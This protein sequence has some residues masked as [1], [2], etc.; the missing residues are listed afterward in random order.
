MLEEIASE[1]AI[2]R[3]YRSRDFPDLDEIKRVIGESE[4]VYAVG[5]GTSY[6][7]ALFTSILLNRAGIVCVP[8][9]SSQTDEWISSNGKKSASIIFSQSGE[10][11]DAVKSME[12]MKRKGSTIIAVTNVQGSR[13]DNASDLKILTEAG[14]ELAIPATRTHLSQLLVSL[15]VALSD[16]TEAYI[17]LLETIEKNL[18][19][20]LHKKEEIKYLAERHDS[21]TIFLGSGLLFP[22]A[23]EASLKLMET[24]DI[25][26]YAFPVREFL[27]GPK[28]ILTENWS[29]FFLSKDRAVMEEVDKFTKRV[30]DIPGYLNEKFGIT[31]DEETTSSLTILVFA[32]LFSYYSALRRGLNPDSPSKLSKVVA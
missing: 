28:Q 13:L 12:D 22:V 27:H 26:S 7:A 6:H 16:D 14:I 1:P 2:V 10:S 19:K 21:G 4:V 25:P 17:S 23:L 31:M 29:V 18:V 30:V 5:N 15:R 9:Y 32:Q 24:S 20:M 3:R 11:V 8:V